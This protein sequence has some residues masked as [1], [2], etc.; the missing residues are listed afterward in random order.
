[1]ICSVIYLAKIR[2]NMSFS[3]FYIIY[4]KKKRGLNFN[5]LYLSISTNNKETEPNL[6]LTQS[7]EDIC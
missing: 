6:N 2:K 7:L 3:I 5:V 1:M 4:N